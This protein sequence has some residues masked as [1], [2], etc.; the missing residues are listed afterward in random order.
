MKILKE[1][2]KLRRFKP[3]DF[4]RRIQ[5]NNHLINKKKFINLNQ[6]KIFTF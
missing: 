3:T 4:L 1:L 6:E 2:L 5:T